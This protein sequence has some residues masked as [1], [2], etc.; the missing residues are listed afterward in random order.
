MRL[1]IAVY[2]SVIIAF[3]ARR[4]LSREVVFEN[5][6]SKTAGEEDLPGVVEPLASPEEACDDLR[7]LLVQLHFTHRNNSVAPRNT[8]NTTAGNTTNA[9]PERPSRRMRLLGFVVWSFCLAV[10]AYLAYAI[11]RGQCGGNDAE[12]RENLNAGA[13]FIGLSVSFL[14][15]GAMQEFIMTHKYSHGYFPSPEALIFCNRVMI[16]ISAGTWLLLTRKPFATQASIW[17]AIP[18]ISVFIGSTCQ[19]RSLHYITFPVHIGIKSAIIVPTMIL[20]TVCLKAA[21][22]TCFDY[23]VAVVITALVIGFNVVMEDAEDRARRQ[24]TAVGVVLMTIYL[25]CESITSVSEKAVFDAFESFD[26]VQMMMAEGLFSCLYSLVVTM[27]YPGIFVVFTFLAQDPL[28]IM[29]IVGLALCS[30]LGQFF[31]YYTIRRHGPVALAIM[32]TLKQVFALM[33]SSAIFN[34]RMPFSAYL[35]SIGAFCV[36]LAKHVVKAVA[37][38]REEAPA[39]SSKSEQP[40]GDASAG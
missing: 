29:H 25:V 33:L 39:V 21:R 6:V 40:G 31:I 20:S 3:H 9:H 7:I 1:H 4:A 27:A 36:L 8:N 17:A 23:L 32:M 26:A 14:A 30:T 13:C 18:A 22:H 16:I 38:V 2:G 28:V 37:R 24:N 19:Y 35:L 34:H 11:L 10:I 15:Y 12:V 5:A